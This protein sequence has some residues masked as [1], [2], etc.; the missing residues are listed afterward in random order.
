MAQNLPNDE[1]EDVERAVP[2]HCI[3]STPPKVGKLP[4]YDDQEDDESRSLAHSETR[5][6]QSLRLALIMLLLSMTVFVSAGVYKLTKNDEKQRFHDHV[7]LHSLRIVDSFHTAI[8]ERLGAINTFSTS[9]TSHARATDQTFPFVTIQDFAVRGSDLRVQAHSHVFHY[10]PLINES[11]REA[12]EEYA[13]LNRNQIDQAFLDDKVRTE[14]QDAELG[15]T[16]TR[17]LETSQNAT[18]D[19]PL[20]DGTGYNSRIWSNGA[21][22]PEGGEPDGLGWYLPLWQRS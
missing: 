22:Y 21:I 6:V 17:R 16:K 5:L 9:I 13:E 10:M 1:V 3:A 20:Q 18:D 15:I 2:V 12:W 19:T 11:M 8:S 4:T 14:R 7:R